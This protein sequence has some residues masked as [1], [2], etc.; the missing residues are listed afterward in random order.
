M[1]PPA[2]THEVTSRAKKLAVAN[3][4]EGFIIQYGNNRRQE[5]LIHAGNDCRSLGAG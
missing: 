5:G 2:P 3:S 4:G 1:M